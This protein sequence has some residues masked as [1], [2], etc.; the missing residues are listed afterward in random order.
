MRVAVITY[1]IVPLSNYGQSVS[2]KISVQQK[3]ISTY[4][5]TA[6]EGFGGKKKIKI[7]FIFPNLEPSVRAE[8]LL[9]LKQ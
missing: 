5:Y 1:E 2:K 8:D 4:I 3:S 7:E 9:V 6:W